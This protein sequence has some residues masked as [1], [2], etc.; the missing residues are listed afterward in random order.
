MKRMLVVVL[1]I[2]GALVIALA[3]WFPFGGV[4]W[5]SRSYGSSEANPQP[6][7]QPHLGSAVFVV[8]F[9]VALY[10]IFRW[11]GQKKAASY[12][13]SSIVSVRES[14]RAT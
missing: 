1:K 5:Q 4:F 7:G 10:F 13:G 2:F 8:S 14:K 12:E 3:L 6:V 11:R 9:I